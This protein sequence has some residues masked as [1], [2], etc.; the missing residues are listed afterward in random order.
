MTAM[1]EKNYHEKPCI[2]CKK[3][4]KPNHPRALQC[5]A[6][7]DLQKCANC[8][9]GHHNGRRRKGDS[10][11]KNEFEFR[12]VGEPYVPERRKSER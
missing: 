6:C 1:M 7:K 2:L 11:W 10:G 5:L 12:K 9:T 3:N 8:G 4:F